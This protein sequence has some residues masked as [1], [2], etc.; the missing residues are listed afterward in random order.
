MSMNVDRHISMIEE[1]P[2]LPRK[3]GLSVS[4]TFINK[5]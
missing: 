2:K 1:S 4:K 5:F 3:Q